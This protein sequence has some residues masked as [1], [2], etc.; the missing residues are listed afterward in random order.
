M[1]IILN[2]SRTEKGKHSPAVFSSEGQGKEMDCKFPGS[3]TEQS[4]FS[5]SAVSVGVN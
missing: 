3:E 4:E 2:R 1:K 5:G